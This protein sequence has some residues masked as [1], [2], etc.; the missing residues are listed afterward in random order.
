MTT[1]VIYQIDKKNNFQN[2][3]IKN[4]ANYSEK[5]QDIVCAGIS[6]ITNGTV[7]FLYR[8]YK[9]YCQISYQPTKVIINLTAINSDC[10]L[11]LQLTLYQLKNIANSY[12][13]YLKIEVLN[14]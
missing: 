2:I 4:H 5:G 12:P 3:L 13:D 8:H 9:K 7:N 11:C 10:Q 6:A 14:P 1:E